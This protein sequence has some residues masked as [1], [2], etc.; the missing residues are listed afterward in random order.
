MQAWK[1]R[2]FLS[3]FPNV[4]LIPLRVVRRYA[5]TGTDVDTSLHDTAWR[6][7]LHMTEHLMS[8]RSYGFCGRGRV[9]PWGD[10]RHKLLLLQS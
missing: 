3:L 5:S 8:F 7:E 6:F 4:Y 2:L 10:R 1:S 9:H